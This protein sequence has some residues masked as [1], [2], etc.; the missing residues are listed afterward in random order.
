MI[1]N[2]PAIYNKSLNSEYYEIDVGFPIGYEENDEF[3]INN[4]VRL[5][6]NYT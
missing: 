5:Y 4:H 6:I 3:Y 1:D 2:L